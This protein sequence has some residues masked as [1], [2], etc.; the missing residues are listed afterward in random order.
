MLT[1][2]PSVTHHAAPVR[3]RRIHPDSGETVHDLADSAC[4]QIGDAETAGDFT[5]V[6]VVL[7]PG[8]VVLDHA[9]PGE[10][11]TIYVL[12]G[13][14]DVRIGGER[15]RLAVG[16]Y[17]LASCGTRHGFANTGVHAVRLLLIASPAI[18]GARA[19]VAPAAGSATSQGHGPGGARPHDGP[20]AR[21]GVA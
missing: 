8:A 7:S 18:G 14:L 4:V 3:S 13:A 2:D 5:L 9:H 12:E 19:S 15:R 11:E 21:G 6:E 1:A 20:T 16:E 17:V 10:D